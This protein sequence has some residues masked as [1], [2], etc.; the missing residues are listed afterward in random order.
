M[1]CGG[2]LRFLKR[3]K[4]AFVICFALGLLL[5]SVH[6][7]N[8]IGHDHRSPGPVLQVAHTAAHESRADCADPCAD[9]NQRVAQGCSILHCMTGF[10]EAASALPSPALKSPVRIE[11]ANLPVLRMPSGLDRPPKP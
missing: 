3:A 1:S 8:A 6:L 11:T 4:A 2:F 5:S 10:V 9:T 7:A